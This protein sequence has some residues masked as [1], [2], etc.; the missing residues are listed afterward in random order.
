MKRDQAELNGVS[1]GSSIAMVCRISAILVG[2]VFLVT[3][4][5]YLW[6]RVR[7]SVAFPAIDL[8]VDALSQSTS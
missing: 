4:C 5:L 8:V 7:C 3:A 1:G 6:V 2:T